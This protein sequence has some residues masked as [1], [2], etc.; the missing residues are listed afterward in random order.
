[1]KQ[2]TIERLLPEKTGSAARGD[3]G[4]REMPLFSFAPPVSLPDNLLSG[5]K[6]PK[7]IPRSIKKSR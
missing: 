4:C 5:A 6:R 2:Y 1:V 7:I 3:A